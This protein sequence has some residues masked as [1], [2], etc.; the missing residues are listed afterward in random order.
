M[1]TLSAG[2]LALISF[3]ASVPCARPAMQEPE[4][5]LFA[6][7]KNLAR[8]TGNF[9]AYSRISEQV[10]EV[11]AGDRL[12]YDLFVLSSSPAARGGIDVQF[13]DASSLR[14][15]SAVDDAGR[16]AHGD[17]PLEAASGAW[18]HRTFDL[19]MHAGKRTSRWWIQF[20]GDENGE[21]GQFVANVT[22][23]RKVGGREPVELLGKSTKRSVD[24]RHGYSERVLTA[25]VER[26]RI[27]AGKELD[28]WVAERRAKEHLY[29]E[30]EQLLA[31]VDLASRFASAEKRADLEAEFRAAAKVPTPD[32]FS[33]TPEAYHDLLHGKRRA[34]D[35][36]HPLM[37]AYTGLLVGHAHIDLQWLWEWPEGLDFTRTT[38]EQALKFMEEYPDFTFTQS[39]AGLYAAVEQQYPDLFERIRARAKEGRW[40][41]VGGR[42]CEGDTNLISGESHAR[43]F[44]YGQRYYRERFGAVS[45]VG[46]EPDTFGHAATMP[47]ILRL[48]GLDSYYFCRGGKSAP[49]FWWEGIDGSKVLAFDEPA[50]GSWYNSDVT[51]ESVAELLSFYEKTGLKQLIWVYGVGNHGGG[52]T[53][54]QIEKARSWV[55]KDG[56]PSLRF[57]TARAF[58]DACLAKPLDG[59]PVVAGEMNP[60][61]DGCYTTHG[62]IK[63][64]NRDSEAALSTAEAAAWMASQAGMPYPH[65]ELASGWRDV[66][67]NHHHDTLPGSGIH[68][69][70]ELSHVQLDAV[71]DRARWISRASVRHL[72]HRVADEGEGV[73]VLVVNPLGWTRDGMAEATVSLPAGDAWC[74]RSADGAESPCEVARGARGEARV[75][76]VARSVPSF[77][78]AVYRVVPAKSP[79]APAAAAA[80]EERPDQWILTNQRAK[81]VLDK[82][83]GELV[84][85]VVDGREVLEGARR[86]NRIEAH[87]EEPHGMSAWVLGP[88]KTVEPVREVTSTRSLRS[89]PV[90]SSIEIERKYRGSVLKQ[91]ISLEAGSTSL[92]FRTEIDWRE[93]GTSA[94]PSPLL[95]VAFPLAASAEGG[96]APGFE[97][98]HSIPFGDVVRPAD[99]KEMPALTWASI[100]D[101]TKGGAALLNDSKHGVSATSSG[102]LRLSLIRSSYEPDPLPDQGVHVL[103][104][105]LTPLGV[106]AAPSAATRAGFELNQPLLAERVLHNTVN[107]FLGDPTGGALPARHSFVQIEGEHTI[108]TALK[109]AERGAGSSDTVLRFYQDAPSGAAVRVS[110]AFSAGRAKKVN[111]LED[112][113]AGEKPLE[114][115]AEPAAGTPWNRSSGSI[116]AEKYQIVT[117]RFER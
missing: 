83:T 116:A 68:E 64:R 109:R 97:V 41:F 35:H 114:F 13:D 54:E 66:L 73:G 11:R 57:G 45:T 5:C 20:E 26:G 16:R 60:V 76:F 58:F 4:R 96:A 42:W 98:R 21:Y 59:L 70:Y 39:S 107:S 74:V 18:L 95:R 33:G 72:A 34:L 105:A 22:I 65:E 51:D 61:F 71:L 93:V 3:L 56:R 115:S 110:T 85:F 28:A 43:H 9:F 79:G 29:Y 101:P 6:S 84:S 17:A 82:A 38:F 52:P 117:L 89:G 48:G 30:R 37:K 47:Q 106:G 10:V 90:E 24:M 44:L 80:A 23:V 7:A 75:R 94:A 14:D 92:V 63:K 55:G 88:V 112:P 50:S 104:Y 103:T 46:W 31:E 108:A 2:C 1:L 27:R 19:S 8:G 49:L 15:S 36:A 78:Y 111:F 102:E 81:A 67:W 77:G 32:E 62:D 25:W 87:L 100:L 86:G 40:E 91:Q 99:G 53:R 113:L 12:E 69:S